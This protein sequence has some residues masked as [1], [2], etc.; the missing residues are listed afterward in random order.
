MSIEFVDRQK[1]RKQFGIYQIRN[2]VNEKVYIGQ[3]K[4]PFNKRYLHH[5]WKLKKGTHNN[6]HLQRAFDLYSENSFVFEVVEVV[7]DV[8]LLDEKEVAYIK[9]ARQ[10]GLCY[11]LSDGGQGMHGIP[12]PSHVKELL[13]FLNKRLNTGKHASAETK[14]RMSE[15][16]KGTKRTKETVLKMVQTKEN[17][18][19]SG[20]TTKCCKLTVEEVKQIKQMLMNGIPYSEIANQFAVSFSNINA[21]RSNRSWRYVQ[22]EGWD[23]YLKTNKRTNRKCKPT[24]CQA[25]LEEGAT[26]I[27]QEST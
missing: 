26:T 15:S 10:K 22:V 23:K 1:Y 2:I 20:N 19:L 3:T 16:R 6:P 12:M 27:S 24:L 17:R 11:N 14:K 5:V 9:K 4:Q 13:V 21:I 7:D 18:I 8:D 25:S